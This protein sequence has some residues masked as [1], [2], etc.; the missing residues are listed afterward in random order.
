MFLLFFFLVASDFLP[1]LLMFILK[2]DLALEMTEILELVFFFII[3]CFKVG[4]IFSML[5]NFSL[6]F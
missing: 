1:Y 5:T 2:E 4:D 6:Q 3:F